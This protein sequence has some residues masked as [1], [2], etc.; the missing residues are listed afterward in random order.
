MEPSDDSNFVTDRMRRLGYDAVAPKHQRNDCAV[1]K[2]G[3]A[4][5]HGW[6]DGN[7]AD[8]FIVHDRCGE[9]AFARL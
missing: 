4:V 7:L 9:D 1:P 8:E 5:E 2:N 6:L 3:T